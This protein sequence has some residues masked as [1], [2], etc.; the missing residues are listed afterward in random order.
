MQGKASFRAEREQRDS[1]GC[2]DEMDAPRSAPNLF[3]HQHLDTLLKQMGYR[4]IACGC[5]ADDRRLPSREM[6]RGDG[7]CPWLDEGR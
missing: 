7:G 3:L 6:C 4:P 2:T 5:S 1:G